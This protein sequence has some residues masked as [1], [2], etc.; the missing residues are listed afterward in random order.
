M[1]R[2]AS[3]EQGTAAH[4]REGEW[5]HPFFGVALASLGEEQSDLRSQGVPCTI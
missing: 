1:H 5:C 2:T 3:V 4:S